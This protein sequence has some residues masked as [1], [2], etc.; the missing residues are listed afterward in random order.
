MARR[1]QA[2]PVL[3]LGYGNPDRGDDALGPVVVERVAAR[4]GPDFD[5]V[6]C[7]AVLALDI[8]HA[9][10]L[11]GRELVVFVD[12]TATGCAPFSLAPVQP[13]PTAWYSTHALTPSAV[14]RV[15]EQVSACP[16]PTSLLLAIRGYEFGLGAP[17]SA[18]AR[19]NLEA[20]IRCLWR[21]L[22][23]SGAGPSP[24]GY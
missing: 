17:L 24:H 2:A 9:L 6:A 13:E 16:P 21:L 18:P 22:E 4:L 7:L 1:N 15:F 20:A 19:D 14:L 23:A 8:L 3:L 12:A 5:G 10:D 11:E